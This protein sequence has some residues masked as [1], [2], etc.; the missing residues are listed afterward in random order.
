MQDEIMHMC[1][2]R[3]YDLQK[4][5]DLI[6]VFEDYHKKVYSYFYY[7]I[8]DKAISEDLTSQVFE[9]VI[10]NRESYDPA[11]APIEVWLFTITRNCFNNYVREKKRHSFVAL[12]N[13]IEMIS[14]KK[15]PE[16]KVLEGERNYSLHQALKR[17]NERERNVIALKFGAQLNNRE[18][19]KI[20]NLTE[21]NVGS[22]VYRCMKKLRNE[23]EKEDIVCLRKA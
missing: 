6:Q 18:I 15:S 8:N 12:D 17:L 4:E 14:L 3:K 1:K 9:K 19:A 11:K 23:L 20:V 5:A 7:R 13:I 16:E 10:Q 22:I 2:E 21:S